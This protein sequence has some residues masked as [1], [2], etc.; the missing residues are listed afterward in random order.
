MV[1]LLSRL[2][3]RLMH[4]FHA[5]MSCLLLLLVHLLPPLLH[6]ALHLH[7]LLL[8]CTEFRGAGGLLPV[9]R[10]TSSNLEVA[11]QGPTGRKRV[12]GGGS[13]P[14][15]DLLRVSEVDAGVKFRPAGT[16][17][18]QVVGHLP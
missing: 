18:V 14:A 17:R 5:L 8:G 15:E 4:V 7:L 16:V 3:R 13:S 1:S 9:Q 2:V 6:V 12:K 10:S 11:R